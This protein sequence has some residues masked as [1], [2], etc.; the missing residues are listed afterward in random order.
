[1]LTD[2]HLHQCE[3]GPSYP[4]LD[5]VEL[6]VSCSATRG[7]WGTTLA[8][9]RNNTVPCIGIHPW[10]CDQ[11]NAD[12]RE[13]MTDIL[14]NDPGIHIGEIGLD[15]KRASVQDQLA[16][17]MEQSEMAVRFDR[18]ACIHMVGTERTV[19]DEFRRSGAPRAILHSYGSE[20]CA[21]G[22]AELGC[23]MS[24]SPRI[25][26]RSEVRIG[27]LLSKIPLENLLLETDSPHTGPG[28]TS[29]SGFYGR[30]AVFLSMEPED[31]QEL[32]ASNLKR[33]LRC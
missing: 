4:D 13:E 3:E 9:D 1:M 11:W 29:L 15:S 22:F 21:K 2:A 12:T 31:L 6:R 25:L 7:E 20:D 23:M 16:A 14:E 8:M 30:M 17:F 26:S 19:L 18:V 5:E 24:L 27:R 32:T 28:F 10:Y 33:I